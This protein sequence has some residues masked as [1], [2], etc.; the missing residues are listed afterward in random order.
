MAF[1]HFLIVYNTIKDSIVGKPIPCRLLHLCKVI[2]IERQD[3][4]GIRKLKVFDLVIFRRS[5]GFSRKLWKRGWLMY[6]VLT[7]FGI[8]KLK[9][10]EQVIL[11]TGYWAM[12]QCSIYCKSI[13]M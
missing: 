11:R 12:G 10:M 1:F 4:F 9:G 5:M 7:A 13:R 8:I 6:K 3:K 2:T